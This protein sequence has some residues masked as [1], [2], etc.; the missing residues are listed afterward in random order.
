MGVTVSDVR[1]AQKVGEADERTPAHHLGEFS[2]HG[3]IEREP[4]RRGN[5]PF[6]PDSRFRT[7]QSGRRR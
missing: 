1:R 6:E 3:G 4:G 5:T 7:L 2:A